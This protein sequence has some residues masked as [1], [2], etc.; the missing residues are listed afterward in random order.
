MYAFIL[1]AFGLFMPGIDNYAHLGGF[2]GGLGI[3]YLL[4]PLKREG[5]RDFVLAVLC[6]AATF[7]AVV[8]SVL[9]F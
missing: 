1:F 2:L 9:T 6:L 5:Q 8:L 3:S 7:L 4:N